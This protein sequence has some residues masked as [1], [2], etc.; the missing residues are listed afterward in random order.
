[1]LQ[2]TA[3]IALKKKREKSISTIIQMVRYFCKRSI[4]NWSRAFFSYTKCNER[5]IC[6]RHVRALYIR[7]WYTRS[8]RR[9]HVINTTQLPVHTFLAATRRQMISVAYKTTG[10]RSMRAFWLI[11]R[12]VPVVFICRLLDRVPASTLASDVYFHRAWITADKFTK[13]IL[14][15]AR[16]RFSHQV[17]SCRGREGPPRYKCC[18]MNFAAL[19]AG[20]SR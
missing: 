19:F 1:M 2:F 16:A 9:T 17:L 20:L 10:I 8:F 11:G 12:R 14:P 7:V 13:E 3:L 18:A 5:R 15:R 4:S 6:G